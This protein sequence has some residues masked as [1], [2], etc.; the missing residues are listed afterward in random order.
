MPL[1][2]PN[3]DRNA[4]LVYPN[5]IASST[6]CVRSSPSPPHSCGMAYPNNPI[7]AACARRSAGTS[8]VCMI[9]VSRGT[10]LVRM[11]SWTSWRICSKSSASTSDDGFS[12]AVMSGNY[13]TRRP[14]LPRS[15]ASPW[16]GV[17]EFLEGA[18]F[19]RA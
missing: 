2:V 6:S 7:S 12:L 19:R 8:L 10:T 11:K 3:I 15:M 14:R 16:R 4:K 17:V 13:Q 9:S 1:L 18:G 5:S